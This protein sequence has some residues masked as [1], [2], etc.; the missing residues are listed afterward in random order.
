[1]LPRA[2]GPTSVE[3]PG[4]LGLFILGIAGRIAIVVLALSAA[5][6]LPLW[7]SFHG[8]TSMRETG[9]CTFEC[10]EERGTFWEAFD[11]DPDC[12]IGD[13]PF[14]R[15]TV[16]VLIA[17]FVLL[18]LGIGQAIAARRKALRGLPRSERTR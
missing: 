1:V 6:Q 15:K 13:E 7:S 17:A 18:G 2:T 11:S 4:P 16:A 3:A 8:M 5:A 14:D 12:A 10:I 9:G